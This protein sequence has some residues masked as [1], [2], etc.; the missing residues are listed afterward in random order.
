MTDRSFPPPFPKLPFPH[1]SEDPLAFMTRVI[2][3]L[4]D[5]QDLDIEFVTPG[6]SY[7]AP[8]NL[9]RIPSYYEVVWADSEVTIFAD[10]ESG[11]GYNVVYF[12][13]N[14]AARVRVRL[15]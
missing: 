3:V 5:Y 8:H 1:V 6:T 11:W 7:A 4:N 12:Q 15:R 2:G 10:M 13:A 9:A 14:A